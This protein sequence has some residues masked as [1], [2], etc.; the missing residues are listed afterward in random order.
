MPVAVWRQLM[1]HYFPGD[2]WLR[3]GTES[4]DRLHAFRSRKTLPS[5]DRTIEAL[6]DE[7][8]DA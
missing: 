6:L 2:A 3:L 4:F 1:D 5:W 8:E 7:A